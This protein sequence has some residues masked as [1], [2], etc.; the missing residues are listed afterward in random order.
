MAVADLPIR[1]VAIV[2]DNLHDARVMRELVLD[3]G[4]EPVVLDSPFGD[5][6]D[7]L[8]NVGE[9]ADAA[10]CDHRL[11]GLAHF[12]G[13]QA[14][15]SLVAQNVPA[16]LVTQYV[17]TDADV[18]IRRW[19]YGVPVLLD[20]GDAD[21]DRLRQGLDDCAR[22]I[23]G[24]YAPG[25]RPRRTLIQIDETA[26]ESGEPV[27]DTRVLS[28]NPHRAVRFPLSL[29]PA[30]LRRLVVPG[31]FLIAMVNIG[32]ERA[33]DLYFKDFERAPEPVSE[34]SLG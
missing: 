11:R 15:A 30:D 16:L 1:R 12:S 4:F 10:I 21:P 23:Q 29:V 17:D 34:E 5:I 20:R 25:R 22:E 9:R 19:R 32:A 13:A 33:Q 3:A 14:V 26:N 31:A 18:S 27:V 2:D 24:F 28:W 6:H 7:L 8:R